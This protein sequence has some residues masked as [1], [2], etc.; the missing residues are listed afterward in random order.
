MN[1]LE[2]LPDRRIKG[3]DV[4]IAGI[5]YRLT[6]RSTYPRTFSLRGNGHCDNPRGPLQPGDYGVHSHPDTAHLLP[7]DGP[8]EL[9]TRRDE[10][11]PRS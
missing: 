3:V 11:V 7:K 8:A 4:T 10:R 9:P 6:A 1:D 2:L 5:P